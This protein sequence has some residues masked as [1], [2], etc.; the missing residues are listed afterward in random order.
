MLG[1]KPLRWMIILLAVSSFA[2]LSLWLLPRSSEKPTSP[3]TLKETVLTLNLGTEPPT[4]DPALAVD[5]TSGTVIDQLYQGLTSFDE[6]SKVTPAVASHW[7]ISPDGKRYLFHLRTD[8]NW[9]D[10]TPVTAQQ[11]VDAWQRILTPETAAQYANFLFPI[12]GAK[13][14]YDGKDKAFSHVGIKAISKKQLAVTLEKPLSFL[15]SLMAL[16][17][18]LPLRA[19]L[20]AKYGKQFTEPRYLVGNGPY[21][22]AQWKH[23]DFIK[24]TPNPYYLRNTETLQPSKQRP[25]I[26]FRMI[27]DAN[28][29]TLLFNN[30]QLDLLES[31]TSISAFDYATYAK[32]PNAHQAPIG[33]IQYLGFNTKKA[34]FDKPLARKAFCECLQRDYFPQLLKSGQ[35]PVNSF[36]EPHLPFYNPAVGLAESAKQGKANWQQALA[37]STIPPITLG[38]RN[39]YDT[40]KQAEILQFFWK[41]SLGVTV[42]LQNADW[43]VYLQRLKTDTPHLFLLTW[44]MDYPDADSFLSLFHSS[45]GNNHTQ[46][47][48]AQFDSLIEKARQSLNGAERQAFYNQAQHI[49]LEQDVAICPLF[50]L[51]KLWVTQPWVKGITF[52][53]L[54]QLMIDH[55]SIEKKQ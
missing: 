54:N 5:L 34:P 52:N 50:T 39:G 47:Q 55:A 17:V 28:T 40:R 8:A 15:P 24:L 14:F 4:L 11:F 33:M 32:H 45:N 36:I 21:Q 29:S 3:Q 49:L 48:S 9:S 25:T 35:T 20:L 43:K 30:K 2:L 6:Q 46:W 10:G 41:Q 38:F 12:Q 53:S 42:Q 51:K 7:E 26:L 37:G 22:L 13:A 44:Y 27:P 1:L 31:G 23:E 19:D 16:P 18:A